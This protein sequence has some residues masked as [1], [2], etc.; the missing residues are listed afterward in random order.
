MNLNGFNVSKY[1]VKVRHF[2][3]KVT[4]VNS[5]YV[6]GLHLTPLDIDV[7]YSVSD[8]RLGI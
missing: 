1:F 2:K 8:V 7:S 5:E 3:T 4:Y 6:S